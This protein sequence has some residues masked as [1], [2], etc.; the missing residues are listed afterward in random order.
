M[1]TENEGSIYPI[2]TK[3]RLKKARWGCPKGKVLTLSKYHVF[4]TFEYKL[5]GSK[6]FYVWVNEV[7]LK[8]YCEVV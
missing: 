5:D 6:S 3:V 8:K 4:D 7:S 2:G 1:Y